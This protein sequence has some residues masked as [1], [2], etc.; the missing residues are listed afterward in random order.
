MVMKSSSR[1]NWYMSP[2]TRSKSASQSSPASGEEA[3]DYPYRAEDPDRAP[4]EKVEIGLE[5]SRQRQIAW[6]IGGTV[7]GGPVFLEGGTGR[8]GGG[9][10]VSALGVR[11]G[12][13]G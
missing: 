4:L 11:R 9:F 2:S 6:A 12:G 8:V 10:V 3:K 13:R 7:G 5:A 1:G